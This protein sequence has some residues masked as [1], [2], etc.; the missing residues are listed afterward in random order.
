MLFLELR[1]SFLGGQYSSSGDYLD[2]FQGV[3]KGIPER[4]Y[5]IRI[6]EL[7]VYSRKVHFSV[8]YERY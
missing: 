1:L 3:R 2:T 5:E 4:Y 6:E 8:L 7:S